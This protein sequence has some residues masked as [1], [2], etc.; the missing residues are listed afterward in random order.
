MDASIELGQLQTLLMKRITAAAAKR[1]VAGVAHLGS[2]AKECQALEIELSSLQRRI[3]SVRSAL[4]A[5]QARLAETPSR[6]DV[7]LKESLSAKAIGAEARQRWVDGL[8]Q[9]GIPLTGH[10]KRFRSSHGS[11]V[12]VAFANELPDHENRWF[13]GIVDEPTDIA[14]LLCR[15][16][17]GEL[18]DVVLPEKALK[19]VWPALS[20]HKGSIKFNVRKESSRFLLLVPGA[21]PLDLTRFI[22]DYKPIAGEA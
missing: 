6:G 5:P 1:D 21:E 8:R 3:G 19:A 10:G 16:L 4:S 7:D 17:R 12:A 15:S 13:L 20:R 14:V 11:R 18:H 9:R 22:G 2:L